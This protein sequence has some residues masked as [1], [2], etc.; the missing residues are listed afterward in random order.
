MRRLGRW[1]FTLGAALSLLLC[2]STCV[3]WVRGYWHV[4][5][6]EGH[7]GWYPQPEHWNSRWFG[8]QSYPGT[9]K[10]S[11]VRND[12][13]PPFFREEAGRLSQFHRENPPG[14]HWD[15][16]S[17]AV[18]A[19]YPASLIGFHATHQDGAYGVG[20]HDETWGLSVRPWLPAAL[21]AVLPAAWILRHRRTRHRRSSGL[22]ASCGYDLRAT[23]GRCP[24]CGTAH[25]VGTT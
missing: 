25:A 4:D 16:R 23:P 24:E 8:V 14:L 21:L 18:E 20:R 2:V 7:Y 3:L 15:L 1:L 13:A 22:C 6:V 9:I 11:L 12:F 5:T 19:P 10:F 17:S